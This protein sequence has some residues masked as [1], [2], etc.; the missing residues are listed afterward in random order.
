[1]FHATDYNNGHY[2]MHIGMIPDFDGTNA[3]INN[4][5]FMYSQC[6]NHYHFNYYANF[7][8]MSPTVVS[9]GEKRGFCLISYYRLVNAEWSPLHN[10]YGFCAFQGIAAGWADIYSIGL[11]CQWK[12]VT[13]A[14]EPQPSGKLKAHANFENV[15]CEGLAI[16][17]NDGT[18]PRYEPTDLETCAEHPC[19]QPVAVN[20]SECQESA[21]A[22][23]NNEDIVDAPIA[24]SNYSYVTNSNPS[25]QLFTIGPL[26]D[27]EWKPVSVEAM[28][29]TCTPGQPKTL[30]C[31]IPPPPI[32]EPYLHA[33]VIRVCESS[34]KLRA[35]LACR[36]NESLANVV[37]DQVT[38]AFV[39]VTFTCPSARDAE[40]H[41]GFYSLYMN[42]V[43]ITDGT[44]SVTC[45]VP[46]KKRNVE[47]KLSIEVGESAAAY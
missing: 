23:D 36:Y 11:P 32:S 44:P 45:V 43:L 37:I 6:H 14:K 28:F 35:G 5:Q 4:G 10:P 31:S 8:W 39:S 3:I 42:M 26:R 38:P 34:E 29:L 24:G 33:Q 12:D 30:Q 25:Q 19:T 13:A 21:G 22:S 41:G 20:K 27:T 15:L 16:C 9:S 2:P 40:E 17:E 18:T 1:M 46:A 7:S 47:E